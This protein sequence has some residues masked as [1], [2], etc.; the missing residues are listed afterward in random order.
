MGLSCAISKNERTY[1]LGDI[2]SNLL[3]VGVSI[4]AFWILYFHPP[5]NSNG[6]LIVYKRKLPDLD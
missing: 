1:R 4:M 3:V 2:S 6:I 5:Q